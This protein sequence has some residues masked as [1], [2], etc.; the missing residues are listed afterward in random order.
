M[1]PYI[2]EHVFDV[3]K[4]VLYGYK[5][6]NTPP[7]VRDG[8]KLSENNLRA[9]ISILNGLDHSVYVKVIHCDMKKDTWDKLENIYEGDAKVKGD[10]LQTYRGNFEQLKMKIV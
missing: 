1:K 9:T 4:E 2:Q 6:P 8:K 10:K 7:I 3:W 5:T